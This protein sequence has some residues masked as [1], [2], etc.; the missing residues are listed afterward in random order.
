MWRASRNPIK[1]KDDFNPEAMKVTFKSF[2]GGPFLNP[3]TGIFE[4]SPQPDWFGDTTFLIRAEDVLGQK[5]SVLLRLSFANVNDT[6][7]IHTE[8]APWHFVIRDSGLNAKIR[9]H[10]PD[11]D[12]VAVKILAGPPGLTV[13]ADGEIRWLP[14]PGAS[15]FHPLVIQAS[16]ARTSRAVAFSLWVGDA[17][18][19]FSYP[20]QLSAPGVQA[21]AAYPE[22]GSRVLVRATGATAPS[23]PIVV[24]LQSDFANP[25]TYAIHLGRSEAPPGAFM[26]LEVDLTDGFLNGRTEVLQD[27]KP[28]PFQ[29]KDSTRMTFTLTE[30]RFVF[31]RTNFQGASNPVLWPG[32]GLDPGRREIGKSEGVNALGR[33]IKGEG[34]GKQSVFPQ[35]PTGEKRKAH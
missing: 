3:T 35:L 5:D 19:A 18:P 13:S 22:H 31:I 28:L 25:P 20:V 34:R 10:D 30:D 33:R 17:F 11:G 16:D 14:G 26:Q 1:A 29:I 23:H 2:G 9:I 4:W 6:P 32:K 21:L 8:L 27:W 12:A 7:R 24:T 15:G